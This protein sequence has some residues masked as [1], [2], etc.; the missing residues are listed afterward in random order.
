MTFT[1]VQ[2]DTDPPISSQLTDSGVPID[3]STGINNIRFHMED[4]FNRVVI[5]D[6]LTG[7]VNIVDESEGEVEYVWQ[8]GDTDTAG[9]YK[10]EWQ[11][12]YDDGK[13][14]TTFPSRGKITVEIMEQIE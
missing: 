5:S 14:G 9:T 7:R 10:A 3:L 4:K 6:D 8:S 1:I 11:L 13:V 2:E 12:L